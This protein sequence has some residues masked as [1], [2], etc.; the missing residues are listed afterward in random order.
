MSGM[1]R[2]S[3]GGAP[4]EQ[5]RP[6]SGCW[7]KLV[8]SPRGAGDEPR[9]MSRSLGTISAIAV[10]KY[11]SSASSDEQ[12]VESTH[13]THRRR[14]SAVGFKARRRRRAPPTPRR[15][16]QEKP[17]STKSKKELRPLPPSDVGSLS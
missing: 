1:R 4:V 17:K 11:G 9:L 14:C 12:D 5:E 16:P 6:A 2:S 8:S 15:K 10:I 3:P 7:R 13:T